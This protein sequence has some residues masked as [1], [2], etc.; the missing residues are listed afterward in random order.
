MDENT[1]HY[2]N[3]INWQTLQIMLWGF[4][5]MTTV[6]IVFLGALWRSM[7]IQFTKLSSEIRDIRSD[8]QDIDRRL[9][10][11]EGAMSA[12]ECCML[13]DHKTSEKVD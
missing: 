1:I 11:I 10:R 5:I 6:L 13:K 8:I 9:C 12:K 7:N 3:A 4:G 2:I